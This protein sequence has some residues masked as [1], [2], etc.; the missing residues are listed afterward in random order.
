MGN[1]R[2]SSRQYIIY[3]SSCVCDKILKKCGVTCLDERV[4][5]QHEGLRP[6]DDELI[7][8]GDGMRPATQQ[9]SLKRYVNSIFLTCCM[10]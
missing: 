1:G 3:V 10:Q 9:P 5:V 6:A 8:A 2:L 7:D 4:D